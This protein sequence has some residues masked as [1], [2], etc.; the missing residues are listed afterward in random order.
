MLDAKRTKLKSSLA[1]VGQTFLQTLDEVILASPR[2]GPGAGHS[3]HVSTKMFSFKVNE[4]SPTTLANLAKWADIIPLN[5]NS[6]TGTYKIES[7]CFYESM[8]LVRGLTE[9]LLDTFPEIETYGFSLEDW[10]SPL[11]RVMRWHPDLFF[12][13][14]KY[15]LVYPA[16]RYLDQDLPNVPKDFIGGPILYSGKIKSLIKFKICLKNTKCELNL[17]FV[18]GMLQGVKRGC[19]PVTKGNLL[20]AYESHFAALTKPPSGDYDKIQSLKSLFMQVYENFPKL[21]KQHEFPEKP[22][23]V[24]PTPSACF[25][26]SRKKGGQV[27]HLIKKLVRTNKAAELSQEL[28]RMVEV[29]PGVVTADYFSGR[30]ISY[31]ELLHLSTKDDHEVS[32]Q[33]LSEP[34]KVRPITKGNAATYNASAFFQKI[35]HKHL[36]KSYPQFAPIGAP[37]G[38]TEIYELLNREKDL[39]LGFHDW[40]SGDYSAATDGIS[41]TATKLCFEMALKQTPYGQKIKTVLR[42]S[43]YEQNLV[44]PDWTMISGAEQ[45]NGQLMGSILSFPILCVVNLVGYWAALEEYT[46]RHFEIKQLPVLVNGDDILFRANPEFYTVW[47]KWVDY[48]GFKLSLG[49]N[50]YHKDTLTINS[51]LYQYDETTSLLTKIEFLN[52][53]LLNRQVKVTGRA[54][55]KNLPLHSYFNEMMK[56]CHSRKF[57]FRRFLKSYKAEILEQTHGGLFNLFLPFQRGGLGLQMYPEILSIKRRFITDKQRRWATI[58]QGQWEEDMLLGVDPRK[59]CLALIQKRECTRNQIEIHHFHKFIMQPFI[60]PSEEGVVEFKPDLVKP[61]YLQSDPE[62]FFVDEETAPDGMS[63]RHPPSKIL[64]TLNKEEV[65]MMSI[66]D[67]TRPDERLMVLKETWEPPTLQMTEDEQ[68][69]QFMSELYPD[70]SDQ[71]YYNDP[72]GFQAYLSTN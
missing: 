20:S 61:Y 55:I 22:F 35:L 60:G 53:G 23:L 65:A 19:A 66:E 28:M 45:R 24:E 13:W 18:W 30:S 69:S 12:P 15:C 16:A 38:T 44:Y 56:G 3:N 11:K 59:R 33:A 7:R 41:I 29:R 4:L 50:Y 25:E 39:N 58:L 49:K 70:Q 27:G 72:T 14:A 8:F 48:L 2:K 47:K 64:R 68:Y 46:G 54:A 52:C 43:L 21:Y 34:L 37:M 17:K 42:H 36:F 1:H 57:C 67:I 51:Q 63:Y 5:L 9:I 71:W 26:R 32:V 6:K 62:A 10:L 40:V 31:S